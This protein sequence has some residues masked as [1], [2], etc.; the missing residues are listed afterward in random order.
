MTTRSGDDAM[1]LRFLRFACFSFTIVAV[2]AAPAPAEQPPRPA[3]FAAL[4]SPT[5]EEA[6][7]Q[8]L[9]WLKSTGQ[10][11]AAT[12]DAFNAI[13]KGDK[14]LLDRT[15]DT[16]ALGDATARDLLIEARDPKAAAPIEV[17]A[18]IKDTKRPAFYRANLALAYARSLSARRIHEEALQTL[19]CVRAEQVIDPAAYLFHKAVAE[20]ALGR[21]REA[22]ATIARLIDDA[23]DAPERY[24]QLAALMVYDMMTWKEKDLGAVARLLDNA[25]R[26]LALGRGGPETQK[27]QTDAIAILDKLIEDDT[28]GP[29]GP[30]PNPPPP[31]PGDPEEPGTKGSNSDRPLDD[32]IPLS[33][34][35]DGKLHEKR[36]KEL[37]GV[38]G[39]LPEK[40]RARALQE[41]SRDLPPRYREVIEKYFKELSRGEVNGR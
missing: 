39:K 7:A 30:N 36:L 18:A 11:D 31:G 5:P 21:A 2:C 4:R 22:G 34:R 32:S 15:A 25:G 10:L 33:G 1:A 13:W 26:R 19:V 37:A 41:L 20:H 16:L 40:E 9:D 38:W 23:P 24:K 17:P 6:R 3:T 8:A 12:L 29:R 35:G 14:T 28:D 27:L